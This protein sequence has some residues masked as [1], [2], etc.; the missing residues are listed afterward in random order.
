MR[1]TTKTNKIYFQ[2]M[3]KCACSYVCN[4]GEL[5][6]RTIQ[7]EVPTSPALALANGGG[8]PTL[9]PNRVPIRGHQGPIDDLVIGAA[10]DRRHG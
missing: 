6:D 9:L 10:A 2:K 8:N 5:I 1:Q 7:R 4:L 3:F